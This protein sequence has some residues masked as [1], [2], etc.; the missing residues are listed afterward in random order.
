MSDL[1]HQLV[2]ERVLIADDDSQFSAQLEHVLWQLGAQ[3]IDVDNGADALRT[4]I[5]YTFHHRTPID[6]LVIRASLPCMDGVSVIRNLRENGLLDN[7][8]V[9]VTWKPEEQ[10][11]LAKCREF[12]IDAD[13]PLPATMED[14]AR[15]LVR[16]TLEARA[17]GGVRA[18]ATGH[19]PCSG[20][21]FPFL[22]RGLPRP[23]NYALR[24]SFYRCPFCETTF[25]APRL[26]TRALQPAAD[27]YMGVGLY[28][29]GMDRDYLEYLL[30]ECFSCPECLFTFDRFGFF[31]S[32][33]NGETPLADVEQL[34][35]KEWRPPFFSVNTRLQD[36][37]KNATGERLAVLSKASDGG[38]GLFA[39]H[40]A[41]P[42]IPRLPEDALIS[43]DLARMSAETILPAQQKGEEQ[44]RLYHKISGFYIKQYYVHGLLAK[45]AKG[46]QAAR[47][48]QAQGQA[49]LAALA[50]VNQVRDVEFNVLEECLYCQ[51]R[52][53]FI[54]D[55]LCAS[56]ANDEQKETL[57][58]LRKR[59]FGAMKGTLIRVRQAKDKLGVNTVERFMQPLENRM[60]EL[61]NEGKA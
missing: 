15:P 27:D 57:A 47:E 50:A 42:A 53:F 17:R 28:S 59:S 13:V 39:I 30:I 48:R 18:R 49:L 4:V 54:A 36:T 5:S 2:G 9:I 56:A 38:H 29:R 19:A 33:V 22:F 11:K 25:T 40:E 45:N 37:V 43:Y 51:T 14:V 20:L 32:S 61:E 52:R 8:T 16:L 3:I 31:A 1:K 21:C 55:L 60:L 35:E 58:A 26:V 23:R 6:C 41:D 24:P 46:P 7:L 44:A 34:P 12:G 10:A